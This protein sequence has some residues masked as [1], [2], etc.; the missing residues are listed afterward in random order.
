M[1]D[2]VPANSEQ[3]SHTTTRSGLHAHQLSVHVDEKQLRY[4]IQQRRTTQLKVVSD[5]VA[6]SPAPGPWKQQTGSHA[7]MTFLPWHSDS[8]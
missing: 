6:Y 2:G 4:I 1:F 3:A 5:L 7:G 8:F